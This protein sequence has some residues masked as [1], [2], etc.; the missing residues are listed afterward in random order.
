[1]VS[2]GD[3]GFGVDCNCRVTLPAPRPGPTAADVAGDPGENVGVDVR[4]LT[5]ACPGPGQQKPLGQP[6]HDG[7]P[8]DRCTQRDALPLARGRLTRHRF[9][10]V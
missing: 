4:R 5:H 2:L 10:L 6:Q 9:P 7:R 1:M 3:G 8:L